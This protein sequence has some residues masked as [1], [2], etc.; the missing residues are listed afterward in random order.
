MKVSNIKNLENALD[1]R[2][3]EIDFF[4]EENEKVIKCGLLSNIVF[5]SFVILILGAVLTVAFGILLIFSRNIWVI[6]CFGSGVFALLFAIT[7]LLT[8]KV[9]QK[10]PLS[11]A[12]KMRKY[13]INKKIGRVLLK[14]K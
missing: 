14:R 4:G 7:I 8:L 6:A 11:L 10:I 9:I 5:V 13:T 3:K 12:I 2:E 1:S